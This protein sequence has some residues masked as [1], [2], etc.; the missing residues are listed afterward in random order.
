M[1]L[2]MTGPWRMGANAVRQ[3]IRVGHWCV[4]H[5]A[6]PAVV[7]AITAEG[8]TGAIALD[9]FVK[10]LSRP[11]ALWVMVPAVVDATLAD[12]APRLDGGDVI[13]DGDSHYIDVGTSGGVF[14][15]ARASCRTE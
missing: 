2:G 5:D 13:D 4:G 12:L 6:C 7:E 9:E 15:L 10:K 3:L 8:A 14:G 1:Q 11:R